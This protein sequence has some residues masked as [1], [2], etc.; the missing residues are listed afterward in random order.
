MCIYIHIH[1]HIHVYIY[2]G[3]SPERKKHDPLPGRQPIP[4]ESWGPRP[5]S[6]AGLPPKA[7]GFFRPGGGKIPMKTMGK[8]GENNGKICGKPEVK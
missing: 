6:R 4:V 1:I 8:D 5:P 3:I 2:I 7:G